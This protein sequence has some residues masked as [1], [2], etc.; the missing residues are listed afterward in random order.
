MNEKFEELLERSK[1]DRGIDLEKFAILIV[2]ECADLVDDCD[3]SHPFATFGQK[4]KNH[5]GM[6]L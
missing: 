2:T 6:E 3:D 5:F 4:I 1:F